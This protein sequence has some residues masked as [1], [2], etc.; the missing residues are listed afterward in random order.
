MKVMLNA[1]TITWKHSTPEPSCALALSAGVQ[2]TEVH[3]TSQSLLQEADT[4]TSQSLLQEAD[5][6][7][8]GGKLER[9]GEG[10]RGLRNF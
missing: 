7:G 6:G 5:T 10:A 3:R 4:R 9:A 1:P 8:L 2:G